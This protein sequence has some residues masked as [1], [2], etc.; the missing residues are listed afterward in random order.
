M[1][2]YRVK[3]VAYP[4]IV[5]I[6]LLSALPNF[7]GQDMLEHLPSWYAKNQVT[8]GLDLQGGSHLLLDNVTAYSGLR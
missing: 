5:I 6:G 7:L 2:Q 1:R 8:L 4:A 3:I